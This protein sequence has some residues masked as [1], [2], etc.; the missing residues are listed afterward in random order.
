MKLTFDE[1]MLMTHLQ[2]RDTPWDGQESQKYAYV[3]ISG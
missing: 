3:H 1:R 2:H